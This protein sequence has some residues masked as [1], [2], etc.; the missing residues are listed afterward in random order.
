MISSLE[1][2]KKILG[3]KKV[4]IIEF[5]VLKCDKRGFITL[6]IDEISKELDTSKPTIIA[7]FNLLRSKGTLKRI[8]NGV[9]KITL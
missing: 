8:K 4:D 5:L 3:D 6:T 7:T 2:Y 9:Y 1:I